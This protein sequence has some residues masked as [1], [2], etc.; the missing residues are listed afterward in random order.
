MAK[1]RDLLG[2]RFG[3]LTVC[4]YSHTK[5]HD[6]AFWD[7]LCDC[8][9]KCTVR[10]SSLPIAKSCGCL[11]GGK[12]DD[13]IGCRF[14]KLVVVERISILLRRDAWKATCD[15]GNETLALSYNL[16]SGHTRSCG[17][18]RVDCGMRR[19]A[20]GLTN[21]THGM[22]KTREYKTWIGIIQRCC[23]KK[24]PR[25]SDYGG[26]GISVCQSWID[27]FENF[28]ADMG[29]RPS[30]KSIDRYPNNDGNYEPNN[31]RW[32]TAKEQ[33]N[34]KRRRGLPYEFIA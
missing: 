16:K 4:E 20:D 5:P 30:G 33:A 28:Y 21:F 27:S 22:S 8:G 25:Y 11:R 6:G 1:R 9:V 12:N 3:N 24:N 34:N 13:L 32:A 10:A 7:C 18:M 31:C 17:C 19:I 29:D 23:N 15:C 26:R 2:V 14:G